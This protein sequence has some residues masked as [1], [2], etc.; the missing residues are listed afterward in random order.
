MYTGDLEYLRQYYKNMAAALDGFYPRL[1]NKQTGLVEK[2][3]LGTGGYGDYGFIRRTGPVTYYNALYVYALRL[4]AILAKSLEA[5]DATMLAHDAERWLV[6]ADAISAALNEHN[7]DHNEGLFFDGKCSRGEVYCPTHAQ[8]GNSLAIIGGVVGRGTNGS[9]PRATARGIL[10]RWSDIAEREWGN[11]FYS[12]S[13]IQGDFG[14]RTYAF[15]SYFEIAARFETGMTDS[16]LEEMR[17][18]WGY[19]ARRD[20]GVTFW[21]GSDP[22]YNQDSFKSMAHGWSTGVVALLT[23]YVLGVTPEGLGFAPWKV[24]PR[25]GD[26]WWARGTVPVPGGNADRGIRVAWSRTE[27][28]A[29]SLQVAAPEGLDRGIVAVPVGTGRAAV[30]VNGELV[31][32]DGAVGLSTAK[33]EDGYVEFEVRGTDFSIVVEASEEGEL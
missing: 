22:R 27:S 29:F 32:R 3:P 15:I 19:M 4:A 20:P 25:A 6:R 8:D 2:G 11:A 9:H 17:R 13:F 12:N 31:W 24:K 7:F 28:G 16:A 21:E 5:A 33:L 1:M 23:R 30:K 26:L 14:D 10:E 18:L